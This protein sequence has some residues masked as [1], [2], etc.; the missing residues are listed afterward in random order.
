MYRYNHILGHKIITRHS[1]DPPPSRQPTSDEATKGAFHGSKW[2]LE[3]LL[4][5]PP[6]HPLKRL[7]F[8]TIFSNIVAIFSKNSNRNRGL[9][10]LP[11]YE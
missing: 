9:G 11:T 7:L 4:S 6:T 3:L 2:L 10:Y 1:F 8:V 5:R